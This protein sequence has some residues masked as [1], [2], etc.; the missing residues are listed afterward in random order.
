VGE[1]YQVKIKILSNP[2]PENSTLVLAPNW[3]NPSFIK[4]QAVG[5]MVGRTISQALGWFQ[6]VLLL[7]L[8]CCG[9]MLFWYSKRTS[10]DQASQ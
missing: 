6:Y 10:I 1:L 5:A 2:F 7:A 4:D 9:G 3:D 8:V